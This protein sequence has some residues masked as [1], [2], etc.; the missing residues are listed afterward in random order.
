[1]NFT[2]YKIAMNN[3]KLKHGKEWDYLPNNC[4]NKLCCSENS[5]PII[6]GMVL[7][8]SQYE[9]IIICEDCYHQIKIGTYNK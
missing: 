1:M 7:L 3:F 2:E 9:P 4:E 6:H 8:T 5:D